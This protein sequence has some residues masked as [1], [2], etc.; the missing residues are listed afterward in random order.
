MRLVPEIPESA[1]GMVP[2]VSCERLSA[3]SWEELEE[4]VID[5]CGLACRL[6]MQSQL[7]WQTTLD[8]RGAQ[9]FPMPQY[10]LR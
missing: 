4:R 7:L 1:A 10:L 9:A 2:L 6:A 3:E 5:V 8:T